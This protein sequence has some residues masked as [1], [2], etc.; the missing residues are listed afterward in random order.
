MDPKEDKEREQSPK[1]PLSRRDRAL[2]ILLI[3]LAALAVAAVAAVAVWNLVVVKPSV[4]PKPTARPDTPAETDGADYEDLW[5]PYIPEGGRKDDFYTFLIVGRDTGG[6][7][8]TDTILLAAYDLAN[9][10]LAAM[11]LLRDTM[12]NVS[13]DI[14]KINSVYNVY[15]GG[16]DG[17]EALKQ[18]VGQLVGF[19]P[20][21][22]VVVEWEAVG[23]LVDAVGGVTFDVPLDMSYDD[24]TQDL[25]IHV[26]KGEQKLDGDKAMQLL[27]WRKNNKLVNGHVVNYD[28]EGGD[29]RRIQIQQDFLKATLQQ[30]LEK[31]RDLPTILRLGRI[32]L[33]NVETDLPLNS[34]AYLAQSAVLGGLSMEDV[35]FH[36]MPYQGGMVWSRSLRGMQ[37]YVTPRADELLKLVN[38]YLNPYNADLTR[39]SLDVMSIQAD[40][41]IASSTGRLADT[42]HNALWLEYQ[43]AQN[44]P[45]EETE[46]PAPE[47]TP[48]EESGG[49][50]TPEETAPPE[51]PAPG[52]T[53]P[54]VTLPVEPAPTE[55]PA[56]QTLP[57][58]SW[59]LPDGIPIA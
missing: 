31:V 52:D 46:P 40:G 29:V 6:G 9:Q 48:P 45:P 11:S 55:A 10:K 59:P 21:F 44:A 26:D 38:Q 53:S 57:V 8:N 4:A 42:K 32:F 12:V 30:C 15:G 19:V 20:D 43:A 41:T 7:G 37:D 34:V 35:T 54:T 47:E 13:W 27:R 51:T 22:H 49:P 2:R 58:E 17:I 28:A 56:V 50:E 24:P 36:T 18:E 23:E 33:E 5:M 39:D 25:H 3:V 1:N 14:K 16:V